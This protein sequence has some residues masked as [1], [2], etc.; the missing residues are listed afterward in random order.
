MADEGGDAAGSC[1]IHITQEGKDMSCSNSVEVQDS[2]PQ[3]A[4][5]CG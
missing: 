5:S 2:W 4:T 1:S 3:A